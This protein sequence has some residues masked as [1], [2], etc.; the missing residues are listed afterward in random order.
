PARPLLR[1]APESDET[2]AVERHVRW[3]PLLWVLGVLHIGLAALV[4][5]RAVRDWPRGAV[6]NAIVALWLATGIMQALSSVLNGIL[7]W[8]LARGLRNV[9]SLTSVGWVMVGLI[10]AAGATSTLSLRQQSALF[11]R[12]AIYT[13][14]IGAGTQAGLSAGLP[15]THFQSPVSWLLGSG[16]FSQAFTSI[17]LSVDEE[18]L[19]TVVTRLI[20]MYP[21]APALGFGS[22]GLLLIS[23]GTSHPALRAAGI[24][25]GAFGVVF[26]WSRLAIVL[27]V[28][29]VCAL[30]VMRWPARVRLWLALV[31]AMAGTAAWVASGQLPLLH[32]AATAIFEARAGSSEAR[33][34]IYAE[35]WR[36]FLES[37]WVGWGWVGQSLHP[38]EY[39]P[40]GSHSS[41]FGT[42]Y[43]GGLLVFVPFASAMLLTVAALLRSGGASPA[44]RH[45][46]N[47]ALCLQLVM[48]VSSFYEALYSLALPC[49]FYFH[50]IGK[51]L[52][53]EPLRTTVGPSRA[54]ALRDWSV[55][56]RPEQESIHA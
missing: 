12:L 43:T 1:A 55:P 5:W 45:G 14:L 13:L 35:S 18:T 4:A 22:L 24:A 21:W 25:G 31:L 9:L 16:E 52:A 53:A 28:V 41:V 33:D 15:L 42:L 34:L 19:G 30:A 26:S 47:V 3:A 50:F 54:S 38:T 8:D 44:E 46:R 36:G 39:L 40:I 48:C 10:V 27:A 56:A 2:Q 23:T 20:L 7:Q 29:C 17:Q 6:V 11:S 49:W 32:E 37:P 51:A